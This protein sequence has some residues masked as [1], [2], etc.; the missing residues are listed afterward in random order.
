M[1]LYN[2]FK[3]FSR[4]VSREALDRFFLASTGSEYDELRD[5]VESLPNDR[6]IG[7]ITDFI[8]GVDTAAVKQKISQVT[9]CYL[10]IDYSQ[11]TSSVDR[12][13]VKTDAFHVALT[14]AKPHP[15]DEDQ[16]A[17]MLGMDACM[18]CMSKIRKTM[19]HDIDRDMHLEW[20]PYPA[21]VS[22]F[23][24]KDLSNSFGWTMEFDIKG[25]DIV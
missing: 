6:R 8:F 4:F 3:Y 24:A 13:D 22:P 12:L 7:Q 25:I 10:F 19:R 1:I 2:V 5:E 16:F 9:G 14:V 15:N 11:I 21:T 20:L 23:V 18:E 17:N